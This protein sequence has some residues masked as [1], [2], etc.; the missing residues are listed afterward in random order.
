MKKLIPLLFMFALLMNITACR[1]KYKPQNRNPHFREQFVQALGLQLVNVDSAYRYGDTKIFN[2]TIIGID[3]SKTKGSRVENPDKAI[4]FIQPL[5]G[6]MKKMEYRA[7]ITVPVELDALRNGNIYFGAYGSSYIMSIGKDGLKEY[8]K[9]YRDTLFY[10]NKV[11]LYKNNAVILSMNGVFVFDLSSQKPLRKYKYKD[12]IGNFGAFIDGDDL[13][14]N[15]VITKIMPDS[16]QKETLIL[17]HM[18]LTDLTYKWKAKIPGSYV[19][20]FNDDK[21]LL[22]GKKCYTVARNNGKITEISN[23]KMFFKKDSVYGIRYV[24]TLD[25]TLHK[26]GYEFVN[27]G[28]V[29]LDS[30]NREL[31]SFRNSRYMA[32]RGEFIILR[33]ND[34]L[35]F[36]LINKRSG[37]ISYKI[38]NNDSRED[39]IKFLG[40]YILI[41]GIYLYK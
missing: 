22:Y 2:D 18:D 31:Y 4:Y 16:S 21:F 27:P 26:E 33:T 17:N 25:T 14:F 39:K 13:F 10:A 3:V 15:E 41:D 7:N 37:K 12:E 1:K 24:H 30:L 11:M 9:K 32:E 20:H 29:V 28:F 36:L 8:F 35:Y 6:N 40:K 38:T 19:L 23:R 5:N 34:N